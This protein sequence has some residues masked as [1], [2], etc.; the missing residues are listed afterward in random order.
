MAEPRTDREQRIETKQ[1]SFP[2][3]EG[4]EEERGRTS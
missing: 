1:T 2:I 3:E 4:R